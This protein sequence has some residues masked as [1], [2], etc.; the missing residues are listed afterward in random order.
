MAEH[1]LDG[2]AIQL[3]N[4]NMAKGRHRGWKHDLAHLGHQADLLLIQEAQLE[5]D[6]PRLLGDHY[7]WSF[8]PGFSRPGYN[9]GV[10]SLCRAE[11]LN[12]SAHSHQ[13]PWTRLPKAALITEYRLRGLSDTLLVLNIH[14][15]NFT[16][17]TKRFEQQLRSLGN[18]LLRHHGPIV[19]SGD[20][21]TWRRKRLH[22]VERLLHA[23]DMQPIE[24]A[25][26]HR[27]QVFGCALDHI[28]VRGLM[29]SHAKVQRVYSS[30]HNPLLTTLC[31]TH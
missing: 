13:E 16:A 10:M 20:F 17:G 26:D 8:A 23:L 27:K 5:Y 11:T 14:G 3:L 18:E 29:P 22:I 31:L 12:P 25:V 21:N 15:I 19:F 7:C 30:D 2:E 6:I 1:A 9:T 24:F 4:W 28:F